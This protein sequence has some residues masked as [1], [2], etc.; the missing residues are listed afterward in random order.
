MFVC[1]CLCLCVADIPDVSVCGM[2][3]WVHVCMKMC[4]YM[5]MTVCLL[6]SA[7]GSVQDR[8]RLLV[9]VFY[10]YAL[11]VSLCCHIDAL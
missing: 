7:S 6:G 8:T 1:V 5:Y 11:L 10:H 2:H 3:M 9:T 4:S